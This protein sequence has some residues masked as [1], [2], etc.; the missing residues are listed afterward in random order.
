MR[1]D[2][3]ILFYP[4]GDGKFHSWTR[5]RH[6]YTGDVWRTSC[7]VITKQ[8]DIPVFRWYAVAPLKVHEA[9]ETFNFDPAL[10]PHI[11]A[12]EWHGGC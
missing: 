11:D 1:G 2:S 8:G 9:E 5:A 10:F 12:V 4:N 6:T 7:K 3:W